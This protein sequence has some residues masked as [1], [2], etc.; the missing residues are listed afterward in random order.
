[1]GEEAAMSDS[2]KHFKAGSLHAAADTLRAFR[3]TSRSAQRRFTAELARIRARLRAAQLKMRPYQN[4]IPK[5]AR[6]DAVLD[7]LPVGLSIFD[8]QH[9]LVLCNRAY[10]EMYDVPEELARPGTPFTELMRY[11]V[12]RDTGRD[13]PEELEHVR[14]WIGEHFAKLAAGKAFTDTQHLSDGRTILAK[15]GPIADGGW[16]DVLEDIS[17]RCRSEAMIAHMARHDSLTDLPNRVQLRERL[18]QALSLARRDEHVAAFYLD[19]DRFKEVNDL[20]GHALGDLLL[21]TV[22]GR[23]RGCVRTSDT[24]ARVG[25]DEFVVIQI[26]RGSPTQE[27]AE[28]ASRLIDVIAAPY[29]LNDHHASIGTSVGIA[30]AHNGHADPEALLAQADMA[31]YRAKEEGRGTFCFFE[32]EMN[33][34]AHA[35][36]EL[37]R[38][39]RLALAHGHFELNYQPLVNLERKDISGFEALLRWRHP[40]RGMI[41][42]GDFIPL[43]EETG[44]IVPI[45]E[46][47]LREACAEAAS[48]PDHVK[49]AV[50]LSPVQFKS[51]KLVEM[52][53]NALAAAALDAR[54]L[55]LE[56]TESVLL[57][58]SETTLGTLRQLHD[59]GVRI[60]MD[61]FGTGYSSLSYLRKFPF[62][63]IK[64]DRCFIANLSTGDEGGVA[65]VRA[66]SSLGHAL[67]LVIT[68]EGVETQQQLEIIR[69]EGCDEMQGYI[70]SAAQPAAEIRRFF[71]EAATRQAT[72]R[73]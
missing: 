41:S 25:G 53:F 23:L 59:L 50:N 34:R 36:R 1:M 73:A 14:E 52:V 37:E 42:P 49:I 7:H 2:L 9:R 69:L 21:K 61:D 43:A 13:D 68:A 38:D 57:Q 16:I 39:L 12:K 67:G 26:I 44:L 5:N 56:I 70:F 62:D 3:C 32:P 19:L 17:E 18:G 60:V 27:A 58:D 15:V 40:E 28:L 31:L 71:R 11:Y 20:L 46:W 29:Q 48:W 54:R 35:R 6:F 65:I 47:V 72:A 22:A 4:S 33:T 55:E 30:V 51:R 63:K 24:V 66:I 64:I 10:R 45:G 8:P